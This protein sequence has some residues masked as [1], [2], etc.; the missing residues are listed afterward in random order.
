MNFENLAPLENITPTNNQD[1]MTDHINQSQMQEIEQ[2]EKELPQLLETE[3]KTELD[4]ILRQ[5]ELL[6]AQRARYKWINHGDKNTKHFHSY[7]ITKSKRKL[8][9]TL[10]IYSDTWCEDQDMLKNHVKDF[11]EKLF[12]SDPLIKLSLDNSMLYPTLNWDQWNWLDKPFENNEIKEALFSMGTL[13]APGV[14]GFHAIFFQNNWDVVGEKVCSLVKHC[15]NS[16]QIVE[17]LNRMSLVFLPKVDNPERINQ[18]RPI[19]LFQNGELIEPF[20]PSRGIRQGDPLSSYLFVI[21]M[22]RLAQEIALSVNQGRWKP[23]KLSRNG[24][25]ISHLFFVDDLILFAEVNNS[26]IRIIHNTINKFCNSSGQKVSLQKSN[27]F[28]SNNVNAHTR[29]SL[30]NLIG[31]KEVENHGNYL[32]VPLLHNRI[33]KRTYNNIIQRVNDKLTLW[34]AKSL[35]LAGRIILAK[36]VMRSKY[37]MK[38]ILHEELEKK[39]RTAFMESHMLLVGKIQA[40]ICWNIGNGNHVDFWHDKWLDN[41]GSLSRLC[42][43]PL[44]I[45]NDETKVKEMINQNGNW[46][47]NKLTMLLP[48]QAINMLKA[49]PHP[50]EEN[51]EDSPGW[52]LSEK[53]I[54]TVR[55]TYKWI[56]NINNAMEEKIWSIIAKHNNIPK[57]KTFLW[58]IG[59][60]RLLTHSERARRYMTM[61]A[62]FP[63]CNYETE[64]INHI[65][66]FCPKTLLIWTDLIDPQKI[67]NFLN[68]NLKNWIIEN[69]E[70]TQSPSPRVESWPNFFSSVDVRLIRLLQ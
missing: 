59:R 57:V 24:P 38:E 11:C 49:T 53:R 16:G 61:D 45:E 56:D 60:N 43:Q 31:I 17:A 1:Q 66:R 36:S 63:M 44:E 15:L 10:K 35:S 8:I 29:T 55:S 48:A 12:T 51:L 64:D 20:Q 67:D 40:N 28:Y 19:R 25:D 26:H 23:I 9:T 27:I 47:W 70:A 2:K 41:K 68:C 46:D 18:F 7:T 50:V 42:S 30:T 58:L 32:G 52:I 37:K 14:D 6:W 39:G 34:K 3:L 65:L 4:T 5:E 33:N 22:E 69:L 21:C 13:K 62:S 54:F